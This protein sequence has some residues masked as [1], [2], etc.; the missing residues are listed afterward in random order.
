MKLPT[1]I[2]LILAVFL[3]VLSLSSAQAQRPFTVVLDPGHG[4]HD[5]GAIGKFSKEKDINLSLAI[6]LGQ[7]INEKYPAI[8]VVYTRSTD[9]FIPLQR[10]ADIAN[11]NHADIFFSIH[12]NATKSTATHG[13]ET[14]LLGL[15]KSKSN[16]EVAMKE[17]SVITLEDD[18]QTKYQ[19]FDPNSVDSYIMFEY[20]QDKYMEKSLRLATLVENQ[21][22][23]TGR[24]SRGVKQAGFWV[25]H[26]SACPSVLIELGFISNAA[27]EKYMNSEDGKNR[28]ARC[29]FNA[30]ELYKREHDRKSG[31]SNTTAAPP[32]AESVEH[33]QTEEQTQQPA[34][35]EKITFRVQLFAVENPVQ[36]NN[37]VFKGLEGVTFYREGYF[38]KYTYG[39]TATFTE[40]EQIRKSIVKQ[41]P[42]AYIVAFKGDKK[43]PVAQA[44]KETDKL[45]K[46]E[47]S[48]FPS[49]TTQQTARH[50]GGK[51][52]LSPTL[53][54]VI[55]LE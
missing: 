11:E 7:L 46:V 20:M 49:K 6:R 35:N 9:V 41:F 36:V 10:R 16:L 13:T 27:E 45:I 37:H 14:F 54:S 1:K 15:T 12:T 25:L 39:E 55:Y 40:I 3:P 42:G 47:T 53:K 29:I 28:L 23:N 33:A 43:I 26:K 24:Y 5:S 8:K 17:N 31:I 32:T 21:F 52:T 30:F 51:I 48:H 2:L 19:G 38:Y 34:V 44:I 4:G 18:Y 22:K 50:L